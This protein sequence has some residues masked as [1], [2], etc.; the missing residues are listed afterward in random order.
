MK[1]RSPEDCSNLDKKYE[2]CEIML[3]FKVS[4]FIQFVLEM[5]CTVY[6]SLCCVLPVPIYISAMILVILMERRSRVT[7]AV[8]Q[9]FPNQIQQSRDH[10]LLQNLV[11]THCAVTP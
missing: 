6:T 1:I 10:I 2:Q 11:N 3:S 9:M 4:L 8:L 5:Y 7:S